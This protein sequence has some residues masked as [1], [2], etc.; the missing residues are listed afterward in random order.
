MHG[1]WSYTCPGFRVYFHTY[2]L[3]D[4]QLDFCASIFLLNG[5][6]NYSVKG[7]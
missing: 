1:L 2:D 7:F 6:D 5:I 3:C 4:E